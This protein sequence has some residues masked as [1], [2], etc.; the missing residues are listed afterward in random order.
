M[1]CV[2]TQICVPVLEPELFLIICVRQTRKI[3]RIFH[4]SKFV[5]T[6]ICVRDRIL[7][8]GSAP[9]SIQLV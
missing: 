2:R 4:D 5:L 3:E 9:I 1:I 6:Q 7:R 8:F